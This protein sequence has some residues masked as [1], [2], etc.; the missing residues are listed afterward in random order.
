VGYI[1][2]STAL[3]SPLANVGGTKVKRTLLSCA[4]IWAFAGCTAID[5]AAPRVTDQLKEVCYWLSPTNI[6]SL[7]NDIEGARDDGSTREELV[8]EAATECADSV[9]DPEGCNDCFLLAISEVY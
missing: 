4:A 1:S 3:V 6:E 2:W 9:V 5:P 8:D 7:L